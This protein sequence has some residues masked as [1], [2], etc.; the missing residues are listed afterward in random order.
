MACRNKKA[1]KM[2]QKTVIHKVRLTEQQSESLAILKSYNVN[3]S[4]FIRAAI[5]EKLNRDWKCI[6]ENKNKT[7]CPF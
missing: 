1:H 6:K 2:A 3:L 4:Q 7:Y 5:K